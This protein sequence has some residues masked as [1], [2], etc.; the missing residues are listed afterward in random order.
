MKKYA[1]GMI[2]EIISGVKQSRVMDTGQ[3][4]IRVHGQNGALAIR[5]D[6]VLRSSVRSSDDAGRI[7]VGVRDTNQSALAV[8]TKG[9]YR[10]PV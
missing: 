10:G 9:M 6:H 3:V 7:A 1:I 4:V 5:T 2:G 8:V